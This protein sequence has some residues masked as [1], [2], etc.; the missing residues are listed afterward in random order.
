MGL[1]KT[2]QAL[3][4]VRRLIR[5]GTV[6]WGLVVVPGTLVANWIAEGRRWAPELCL[7]AVRPIGKDRERTWRRSAGRA[8][9]LIT[10]YEQMREPPSIFRDSPPDL[11]IA[12]EAHRLRRAE[13]QAMRGFRTLRS[14][15]LWLLTGTP[16]ERSA[17][18]LAVLMSLLE[19]R[20]FSPDDRKLHASSLRARA[21]SFVLRRRKDDVLSELPPV[22]ENEEQLDLTVIQRHAYRNAAIEYQRES[23]S[24]SRSYLALFTRLT[25]LCD[26]EP[27]SGSSAKLDR[28]VE[29]I[30]QIANAGEKAVVFSHLLR[31]LRELSRRLT[32]T[33]RGHVMIY[34]DLG[35]SE[36]QAAISRFKRDSECVAL[37]ASSRVGSEG[38]TLIEANHAIFVNRWW[39]PSGNKQARDRL[40]R[41][42]Q[43]KTVW[44]WTFVCRGTVETRLRTILRAKT[45]TFK[46]LVEAIAMDSSTPE[47][48]RLAEQEARRDT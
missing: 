34:G 35:M 16:V 13:S 8:H 15:R 28:I 46:D 10:N 25:A 5:T 23:A 29:L 39:N 21:R 11:L 14:A 48:S 24:G 33:Q 12:D 38:L 3:A 18:D 31:P 37:L 41:I 44:V 22:V 20:R 27:K 4:A 36:R 17:E 43:E 9:L 30:E 42:G 19:P 26:I 6:G 45:E 1:G 7:V 32:E 2:A 40:V 47:V